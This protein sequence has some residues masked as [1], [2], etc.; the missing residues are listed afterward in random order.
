MKQDLGM[1]GL[2]VNMNRGAPISKSL[3]DLNFSNARR[4]SNQ[5]YWAKTFARMDH[6]RRYMPSW[7]SYAV[8]EVQG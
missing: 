5:G 6:V 8:N 7:L 1:T 4:P 3:E 2:C